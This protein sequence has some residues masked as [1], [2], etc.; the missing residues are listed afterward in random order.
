MLR[1][2]K[3]KTMNCLK[4]NKELKVAENLGDFIR[5]QEIRIKI[6][7]I[8]EQILLSECL[9]TKF[10]SL[11]ED[12]KPTRRFINLEFKKRGYHEICKLLYT[13]PDYIENLVDEINNL[14]F[15]ATTDQEEIRNI[16]KDHFERIYK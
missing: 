5:A 4:K 3:M 10:V 15:H 11:L 1:N 2:R 14:K 16:T 9:K 6:G 12:E 7:K 8:E 13:N